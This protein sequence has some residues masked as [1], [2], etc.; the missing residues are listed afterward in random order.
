VEQQHQQQQQQQQ[1]EH[2]ALEL[3][4][5]RKVQKLLGKKEELERA[6]AKWQAHNKSTVVAK[7]PTASGHMRPQDRRGE[8]KSTHWD[9]MEG[10]VPVYGSMMLVGNNDAEVIRLFLHT[11][12]C[13]THGH[14]LTFEAT[15]SP[16]IAGAIKCNV[17]VRWILGVSD[18]LGIAVLDTDGKVVRNFDSKNK[19]YKR[20]CSK[21]DDAVGFPGLPV[22]DGYT[23]L[24][25]T[26]EFPQGTKERPAMKYIYVAEEGATAPDQPPRTRK[27]KAVE[28]VQPGRNQKRK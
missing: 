24:V 10:D 4:E 5:M 27:R 6:A 19:D 13:P 23:L 9:I 16:P 17:T 1:Q 12:R 21:W 22:K 18:K 14:G 7:A 11:Q 26:K 20:P 3:R 25:G 8:A 15:V 28:G 2:Q